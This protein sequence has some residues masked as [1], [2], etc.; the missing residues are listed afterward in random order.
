LNYWKKLTLKYA[1]HLANLSS[2]KCLPYYITINEDINLIDFY[3]KRNDI[4][5]ALIIAKM[6]ELKTEKKLNEKK[7]ENFNENEKNLQLNEHKNESKHSEENDLG[8]LIQL[9]SIVF[10]FC[11]IYF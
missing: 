2:E 3:V 9:L 6:N 7:N 1:E 10:D 4:N 5:N 8:M 11:L